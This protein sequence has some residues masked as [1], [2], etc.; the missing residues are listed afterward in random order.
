MD[1]YIVQVHR[2]YGVLPQ[3]YR[4][5]EEAW[6]AAKA[7]LIQRDGT[8]WHESS[9]DCQDEQLSSNEAYTMNWAVGQLPWIPNQKIKGPTIIAK[10]QL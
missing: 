10:I 4:S 2:D 3:V 8:L 6:N 7:F 1:L 5:F 9:E